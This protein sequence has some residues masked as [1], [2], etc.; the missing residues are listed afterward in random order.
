[1][2]LPE[3]DEATQAAWNTPIQIQ[4]FTVGEGVA[5]LG[6]LQLALRH[7]GFRARPTAKWIEEFARALQKAIVSKAPKLAFLCEAGWN[8]RFDV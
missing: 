5:L 6:T 3:L 1:M 2:K 4:S 8:K 7:P